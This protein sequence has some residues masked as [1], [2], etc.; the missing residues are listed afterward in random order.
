M[1]DR[2][3]WRAIFAFE[4]KY[5]LRQPLLY[6]ITLALSVLL[7]LGGTGASGAPFGRLHLNAPSV[8]LEQLLKGVYFVLFLLSVFVVSAAVRD[9]D[10][11]T[12]ELFFSKPIARSHYLT[13]RFAGAVLVAI[14]PYVAATLALLISSFMPWVDAS[15]LG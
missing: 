12:S 9:F 14:V 11:R 1:S 10:R 3:V 7:F 2:A 6:L 15:R 4:V 13:A 8:I 5:Q